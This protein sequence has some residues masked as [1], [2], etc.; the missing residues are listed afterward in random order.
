MLIE[1]IVH[2]L[3]GNTGILRGGTSAPGPADALFKVPGSA[4]APRVLHL[5]V[6]PDVHAGNIA[7]PSA[8]VQGPSKASRAPHAIAA[9]STS[10]GAMPARSAPAGSSANRPPARAMPGRQSNSI[11][12]HSGPSQSTTGRRLQ[13]ALAGDWPLSPIESSLSESPCRRACDRE[14]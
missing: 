2:N 14:A 9:I 7:R 13:A 1:H 11:V 8:A 6:L 12:H 10:G 3:Q 5:P 4:S